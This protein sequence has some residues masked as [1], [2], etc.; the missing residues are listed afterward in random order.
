MPYDRLP[1]HLVRLS[2]VEEKDSVKM[3]KMWALLNESSVSGFIRTATERLLK[4]AD[5]DKSL[6][7]L[8]GKVSASKAGR[9]TSKGKR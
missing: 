8:A 6:T 4:E 7:K 3:M 2:Y 1:D 5:A 9:A